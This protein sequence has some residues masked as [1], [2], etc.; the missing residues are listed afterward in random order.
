VDMD[1]RLSKMEDHI[2]ERVRER[3]EMELSALLDTLER[4]LPP[5]VYRQVMVIASRMDEDGDE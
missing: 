4:K 2:E 1:R 5:D 3:V